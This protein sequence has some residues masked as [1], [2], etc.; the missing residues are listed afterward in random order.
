MKISK[1]GLMLIG[2]ILLALV[3]TGANAAKPREILIW[4]PP[5]FSTESTVFDMAKVYKDICNEFEK[6]NNVKVRYETT[7]GTEDTRKKVFSSAKLGVYP[8]AAIIET[9]WVP[10]LANLGWIYPL[11]PFATED[12]LA[13]YIPGS[14][15]QCRLE[16]KPYGLQWYMA[17]RAFYY[18][19]DFLEEVGAEPPTTWID[20][21]TTGQK[22]TKPGRW[23][24]GYAADIHICTVL[25]LWPHFFGF[26][27]KVA[28]QNER[29]MFDE[30]KNREALEWTFQHWGDM[31]NEYKIAPKD[32]VSWID[33]HVAT[34]M[35][36]DQI[37]M[38]INSSSRIRDIVDARPDIGEVLK[39]S[40]VPM[41]K[42]Y[43]GALDVGGWAWVI[44]TPDPER[45]KIVWELIKKA[46]EPEWMARINMENWGIPSRRSAWPLLSQSGKQ[47][48]VELWKGLFKAF[49]TGVTFIRP[50]VPYDR[51]LTEAICSGAMDVVLKKISPEEAVDRVQ[52]QCMEQWEQIEK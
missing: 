20:L 39:A 46:Q 32:V 35:L 33:S 49:D 42:G 12:Y 6:E 23:A 3:S 37:A 52:E 29:P 48:P 47:K 22:L 5:S 41:P 26:G 9:A 36:T 27:G 4:S 7:G 51:T 34:A 45:Q 19:T 44:T 28:Q 25:Q 21:Y 10:A 18:R 17:A 43:R 16:G 14:V 40:Y 31:V 50:V 11:D 38:M 15:D 13:D 30:P 8:D 1:V 24:I 2:C